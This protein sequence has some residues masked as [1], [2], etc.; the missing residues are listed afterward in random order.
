MD[1]IEAGKEAE[2]EKRK[3]RR[4]GI[5]FPFFAAF[6]ML[7]QI[8]FSIHFHDSSSFPSFL[9]SLVIAV[10]AFCCYPRPFIFLSCLVSL[11]N[12]FLLLF[13]SSF[14]STASPHPVLEEDESDVVISP[15]PVNGGWSPWTSWSTCSHECQQVRLIRSR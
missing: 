8:P 15:K 4:D 9:L 11:L 13:F 3:G 14:M 7:F 6:L 2:Y 1:E 12:S 10:I 5:P